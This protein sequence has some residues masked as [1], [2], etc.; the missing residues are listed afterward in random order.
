MGDVA[1]QVSDSTLST[2]VNHGAI[3]KKINLKKQILSAW[4]SFSFGERVSQPCCRDGGTQAR[5]QCL[6]AS[7]HLPVE[8]SRMSYLNSFPG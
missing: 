5:Q 6:A 1:S 2:L 7:L 4:L 3:I 8:L